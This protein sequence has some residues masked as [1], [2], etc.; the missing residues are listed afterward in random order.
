MAAAAAVFA[1]GELTSEIGQGGAPT[2]V[3]ARGA[4]NDAHRCYKRE[5][6]CREMMGIAISVYCAFDG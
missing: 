4:E 5:R 2:F 3:A 1:R 6:V